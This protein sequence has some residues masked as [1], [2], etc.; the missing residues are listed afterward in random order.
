M[1]LYQFLSPAEF[2]ALCAI[3]AQR[4]P[5]TPA[6]AVFGAAVFRCAD[7][8]AEAEALFDPSPREA[9]HGDDVGEVRGAEGPAL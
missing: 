2:D 9:W 5:V 1:R 6:A 8:R 7:A 4:P 3:P